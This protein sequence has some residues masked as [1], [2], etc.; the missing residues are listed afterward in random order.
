MSCL[1][2]IKQ[3]KS[4]ILMKSTSIASVPPVYTASVLIPKRYRLILL[5]LGIY[6]KVALLAAKAG[7]SAELSLPLDRAGKAKVSAEQSI[8]QG[9]VSVGTGPVEYASIEEATCPRKVCTNKWAN[10]AHMG[11]SRLTIA[12][13]MQSPCHSL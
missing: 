5:V 2:C 3:Y 9:E 13:F 4:H 1:T 8:R 6:L 12:E 11:P 10:T 7:V